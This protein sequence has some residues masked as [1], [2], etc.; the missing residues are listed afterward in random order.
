MEGK[1]RKSIRFGRSI[2]QQI[3]LGDFCNTI[4]T[5]QTFRTR[6]WMAVFRPKPEVRRR[7]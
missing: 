5:S 3:N 2:A 6:K 1:I 7:F 4:G